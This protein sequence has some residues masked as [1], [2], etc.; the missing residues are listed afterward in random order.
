[1]VK[2]LKWYKFDKAK[3]SRQKRPPLKKWVLVR[4]ASRGTGLPE[5]IAVGYRKDAA[6][7]AQC[8][9]FVI[10]GLG[11]EVLEWCDCL[12]DDWQWPM[13]FRPI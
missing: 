11:G 5:P 8:P 7:D 3:G 9:Y 10:P 1:M 13:P 12:S 4:L 2:S 6:G